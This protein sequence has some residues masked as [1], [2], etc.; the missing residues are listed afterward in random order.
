MVRG[1]LARGFPLLLK[2]PALVWV[3]SSTGLLKRAGRIVEYVES[4][5]DVAIVVGSP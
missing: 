3:R 5:P 4:E 2:L 1:V